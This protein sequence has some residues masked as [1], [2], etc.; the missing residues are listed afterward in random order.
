MEKLQTIIVRAFAMASERMDALPP[1]GH[2]DFSETRSIY[3][4]SGS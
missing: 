2:G 4:S 1:P 3:V